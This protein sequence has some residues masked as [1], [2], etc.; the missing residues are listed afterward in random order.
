MSEAV[1]GPAPVER[2][3]P[4]RAV[5]RFVLTVLA[6]VLFVVG[7]LVGVVWFG[8]TWLAAAV[9]VGFREGARR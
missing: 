5:G 8:L 6:G 7:W 9:R 4:L 1:A 2:A 3:H